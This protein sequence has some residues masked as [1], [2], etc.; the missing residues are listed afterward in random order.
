MEEAH[1]T[2]A[3]TEMLRRALTELNASAVG[4][5]RA[6]GG[7]PRYFTRNAVAARLFEDICGAGL[8]VLKGQTQAKVGVFGANRVKS[9]EKGPVRGRLIAVALR[10][11]SGLPVGILIATRL[12]EEKKFGAQESQKLQELAPEFALALAPPAPAGAPLLDWTAFEKQVRL[13]ETGDRLHKPLRASRVIASG[14]YDDLVTSSTE[15]SRRPVGRLF[16]L[17]VMAVLAGVLGMHA[18]GPGGAPTA[19]S[20]AGHGMVM[21]QTA[22]APQA[23]GTQKRGVIKDRLGFSARADAVVNP[24]YGLVCE[25]GVGTLLRLVAFRLMGSC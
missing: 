8:E 1:S 24:P 17:L 2:P 16:V 5:T 22:G 18:L 13:K 3:L 19:P 20:D 9:D 15:T 10:S 23:S 14:P 12:I 6:S 25:K 11:A 7:P 21:T 4:V